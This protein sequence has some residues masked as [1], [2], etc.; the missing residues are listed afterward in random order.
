MKNK[1]F[2]GRLYLLS[3]VMNCLNLQLSDVLFLD[4]MLI[5]WMSFQLDL[6]RFLAVLFQI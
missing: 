1:D 6:S 2:L 5:G 4:P 3:F